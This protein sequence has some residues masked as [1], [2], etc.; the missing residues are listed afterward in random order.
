M[1]LFLEAKTLG[2][3]K[4]VSKISLHGQSNRAI[5]PAKA[6]AKEPWDLAVAAAQAASYSRPCGLG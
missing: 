2:L 3:N 5:S 6:G 4:N 1:L